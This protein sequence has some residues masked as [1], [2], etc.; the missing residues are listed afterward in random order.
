MIEE[1][2]RVIDVNDQEAWVLTVQ[3]SACQSCSA[4][5]GCGQRV[6]SK[7]T[8]GRARQVRVA[9]TCNLA[10]GDEVAIG[11]E[12]NALVRASFLV[13]LLPL[14]TM[15]IA[16]GLGQSLLA[17]DERIIMLLAGLGLVLGLVIVKILSLRLACNSNYHPQLLSKL[18]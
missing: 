4:R 11:V 8:G 9:N 16:A 10:I 15:I 2:G 18:E 3:N 12:E 6:L 7:I 5:A 14:I 1:K 17:S 13:Y